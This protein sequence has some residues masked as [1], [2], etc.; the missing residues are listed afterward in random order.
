M[1]SL[2]K[3]P[4]SL[5]LFL[6]FFLLPLQAYRGFVRT[7]KWW[8]V[9]SQTDSGDCAGPLWLQPFWRYVCFCSSHS[10]VCAYTHTHSHTLA[11]TH[12]HTD[13]R[14]H[15]HIWTCAAQNASIF[16]VFFQVHWFAII[17]EQRRNCSCT[18]KSKNYFLLHIP[19]M[20]QVLTLIVISKLKLP[21]SKCVS[22]WSA[23]N[24]YMISRD[25]TH[26]SIETCLCKA[27][28]L[29]RMLCSR[30]S[31]QRHV[32][33]GHWP[34]LMLV[35]V[36]ETTVPPKQRWR[37]QMEQQSRR[38]AILLLP[39]SLSLEITF[40]PGAHWCTASG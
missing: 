31:L 33:A 39:L 38:L 17:E 21:N 10:L 27:E 32:R 16:T 7:L 5:L 37:W 1:P 19:V 12:T 8:L 23:L 2:W 9:S 18:Q 24:M 13:T 3:P 29:S 35:V 22:V 30:S 15:G 36:M 4:I 26:I 20:S 28:S 14:T 25:Y 6:L 34:A 40:P 11:H